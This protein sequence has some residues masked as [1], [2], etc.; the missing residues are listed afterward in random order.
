M[1][2]AAALR[3]QPAIDKDLVFAIEVDCN[4]HGAVSVQGV[5]FVHL[6][7]TRQRFG[8]HPPLQTFTR[9]ELD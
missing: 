1:F 5:R 4:V 8:H 7:F 9:L 6:S 3:S 2:T